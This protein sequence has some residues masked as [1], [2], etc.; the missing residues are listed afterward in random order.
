MNEAGRRFIGWQPGLKQAGTRLACLGTI[1]AACV[2]TAGSGLDMFQECSPEEFLFATTSERLWDAMVRE[3]KTNVAVRVLTEDKDC[4]V[5]SWA[6][7]LAEKGSEPADGDLKQHELD[8][9]GQNG[10]ALTTAYMI[11]VKNGVVLRIR[12]TYYGERSQPILFHSRGNFEA[13]FT[14]R[15]AQSL[16]ANVSP[17]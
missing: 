12:R 3:V 5:I 10:I 11:P 4:R 6:T 7:R 16:G 8:E 14:K 1:F 13:C 17:R 15:I 2:A 9:V